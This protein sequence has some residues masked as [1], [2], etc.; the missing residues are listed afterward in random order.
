[1]TEKRENKSVQSKPFLSEFIKLGSERHSR[2]FP[3][4]SDAQSQSRRESL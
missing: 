1:M 4:S 3:S 2:V